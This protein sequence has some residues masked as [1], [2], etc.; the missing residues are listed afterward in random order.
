MPFEVVF[1]HW[2]VLAI[3]LIGVEMFV[4]TTVFMWTAAGAVVV[5][6]AMLAAPSLAWQYQGLVFAVVSVATALAWRKWAPR[7]N[8]ASADPSINRRGT[9]YVGQR[10]TLPQPISDGR[11]QLMIDGIA[12]RVVGPDLP[13]QTSVEV[14]AVEGAVLRVDSS[15]D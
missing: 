13:E 12:W 8:D 7:R 1:W 15:E 6:A 9:E 11:G 5:G 2:W 10:F 4:T 14:I 3:V